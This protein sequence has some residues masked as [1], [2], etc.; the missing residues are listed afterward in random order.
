MSGPG[1]PVVDLRPAAGKAAFLRAYP[2]AREASGPA[3][4]ANICNS[5]CYRD[6]LASAG[7]RPQPSSTPEQLCPSQLLC[8]NSE[9]CSGNQ[10]GSIRTGEIRTSATSA[11]AGRRAPEHAR[12]ELDGCQPEEPRSCRFSYRWFCTEM[13]ACGTQPAASPTL[14]LT[15]TGLST[16][17]WPLHSPQA[18]QEHCPQLPQ[19]Q[20]S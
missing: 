18:P 1:L 14:L 20:P 16:P 3:S 6:G 10:R 4:P 11:A 9:G 8:S 13:R 17:P 19:E 12:R 2:R 5:E 15:P 7:L